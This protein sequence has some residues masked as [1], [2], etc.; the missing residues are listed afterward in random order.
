MISTT[1][2]PNGFRSELLPM[3]LSARDMSSAALYNAM[4]AVSAYHHYGTKAALAYKSNAVRSLFD[5]LRGDGSETGAK[6]NE[7]TDTQIA[8]SMMLCVYSVSEGPLPSPDPEYEVV[9]DTKSRYSTKR[10]ATGTCTLMVRDICCR[11]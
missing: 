8:A 9:S 10:R 4:L 2:V 11:N 7:I 3:A 6:E 1:Q 5:S